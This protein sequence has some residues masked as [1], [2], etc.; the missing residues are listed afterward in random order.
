M[1]RISIPLFI[2]CLLLFFQCAIAQKNIVK[3]NMS[4]LAFQN[5]SLS[6]ER[7]V[8]KGMSAVLNVGWM[9]KHDIPGIITN[10]IGNP[11]FENDFVDISKYGGINIVPELRFYRTGQIEILK[12]FYVAPFLRYMKLKLT[13]DYV[14]N[15]SSISI[16]G[17]FKQ[18]G[19]GVMVGSQWLLTERLIVDWVIIGPYYASSGF[20]LVASSD[21]PNFDIEGVNADIIET[22]DVPIGTLLTT[23]E[24]T[25]VNVHYEVKTPAFRTAVSIGL[26]F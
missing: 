22:I 13:S 4:S 6:Y 21:D 17:N 15:G 8:Y 19:A 26:L 9:P 1:A 14:Y 16:D 2:V 5:I 3:L 20:D 12:G 25:V 10:R 24:P 7:S 11:D 23:I 18:I